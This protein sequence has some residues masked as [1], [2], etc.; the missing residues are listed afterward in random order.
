MISVFV[1]VAAL[2]AGGEPVPDLHKVPGPA[3]LIPCKV[4]LADQV[5]EVHLYVSA[6]RGVTWQLYEQIT[7]DKQA[8]TFV[9]KKA[10]EYWFAPRVKKKDGTLLPGDLAELAATQRVAVATG[11]ADEVGP[12]PLIPPTVVAPPARPRAPVNAVDELDGELNRIELDLIRKEMKRL[13]EANSLTPDVESKIDSLRQRLGMI[14]DRMSPSRND[15][16]VI[17]PPSSG[18]ST[19]P[20]PTI[21]PSVPPP[22]IEDDVRFPPPFPDA[23]SFVRPSRVTPPATRPVA[24]PPRAPEPRS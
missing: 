5:A 23:D 12:P 14:R 20:P 2:A 6:D 19:L 18:G 10:G 13:S 16:L 21:A 7:P 1:V 22:A 15:P 4:Q 24:P 17:P 3:F 11:S 8:F 9:A